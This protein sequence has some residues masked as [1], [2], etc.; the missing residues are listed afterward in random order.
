MKLAKE[1][2]W[3][4]LALWLVV[5]L[6]NRSKFRKIVYRTNDWRINFKPWFRKEVY[7]FVS[8]IYPD[9]TKYLRYRNIYR[10]HLII[11]IILIVTYQ[12]IS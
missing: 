7:G 10:I 4:L 1:I 6:L 9:D 11:L 2:V 5:V 3:L 12:L 8:S